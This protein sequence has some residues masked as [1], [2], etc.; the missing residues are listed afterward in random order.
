MRQS[1]QSLTFIVAPE[2]D[3]E[4]LRMRTLGVM[5]ILKVPYMVHDAVCPEAVTED[6]ENCNPDIGFLPNKTY[7]HVKDFPVRRLYPAVS[8]S[9]S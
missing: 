3:I 7:T 6:G 9:F 8:D 1:L 2:E 5:G 4:A